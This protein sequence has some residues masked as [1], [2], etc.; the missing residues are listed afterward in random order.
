MTQT[1]SYAELLYGTQW[2]DPDGRQ[3][4]PS[5]H[6][7]YKENLS[8]SREG[9]GKGENARA[10]GKGEADIR[11]LAGKGEAGRSLEWEDVMDPRRDAVEL[12]IAALRIPHVNVMD[13]KRYNNARI[14]RWSLD[15]VGEEA[16]R[17]TL[18]E[19]LRENGI[20]GLP[21]STAAT[22]QGKLNA[23]IYGPKNGGAA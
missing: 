2:T 13:G 20:D 14:L 8:L 16:F 6:T 17:R 18:W 7:P 9:K 23:L 15:R 19:Q 1:R 11:Q 22:F 21:R 3:K 10:S 4:K 5:P 12:A